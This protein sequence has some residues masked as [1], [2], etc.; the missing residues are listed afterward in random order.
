[1]SEPSKRLVEKAYDLD[2]IRKSLEDAATLSG[3]VWLSYLFVFFYIGSAVLGVTDADLLLEKPVKLPFLNTELPLVTFFF[4]AP[5]LFLISHVYTL[6]HFSMLAMKAR[7]FDDELTAELHGAED[8]KDRVRW[9]LP[10][11]LFVQFLAG[12]E[13]NRK[14]FLEPLLQLTAWLT[15]VIGPFLLLLLIQVQFLPYHHDWLT[16]AHR[17]VIFIDV[18]M[19]FLLWPIV[20]GGRSETKWPVWWIK[21]ALLPSLVPILL[22]WAIITFSG[23]TA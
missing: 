6:M 8:I 3:G 4:V 11:N 18:A 23:R 2:E 17:E 9:L 7:H 5:V 15:L 16:Y 22:S 14:G 19:W 21:W 20:L 10:I 12:P 1:M 13:Y